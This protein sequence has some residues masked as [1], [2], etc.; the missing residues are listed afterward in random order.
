MNEEKKIDSLRWV[1]KN[2]LKFRINKIDE[3]SSVLWA[4]IL[5]VDLCFTLMLY[6]F[7]DR[8]RESLNLNI[9]IDT[10][11]K[12]WRGFKVKNSEVDL[13][14]EEIANFVIEWEIEANENADRLSDKEWYSI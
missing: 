10:S 1:S 6:D 5:G 13:L 3:E 4:S 12:G 9:E 11:W 14:M 2:N 8:V 7:L